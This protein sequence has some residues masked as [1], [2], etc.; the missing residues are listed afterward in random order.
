MAIRSRPRTSADQIIHDQLEILGNLVYS[1]A[2]R[3]SRVSRT[4]TTRSGR[5]HRGGTLRDSINYDVRGTTLRVGQIYY[6]K[7]QRPDELQAAINRNLPN[8]TSVIVAEI[9]NWLTP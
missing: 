6:G 8:A 1:E 2:K 4:H 3:N 7:Y 5:Y 9:T